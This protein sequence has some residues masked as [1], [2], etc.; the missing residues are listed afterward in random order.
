MINDSSSVEK[1]AIQSQTKPNYYGKLN[2]KFIL[3]E[4]I[5]KGAS[6]S[7]LSAQYIGEESTNNC[8]LNSHID[9]KI[10]LFAIKICK[11][12]WSTKNFIEEGRIMKYFTKNDSNIITFFE[13][14]KG[15]LIKNSKKPQKTVFY[16]VFELAENYELFDY[17]KIK[18]FG[19]KYGR[20]LFRQIISAIQTCHE[21]GIIHRDVKTENILLNGDYQCKLADFGLSVD[22]KTKNYLFGFSG[23][24]GFLPPEILSNK[25]YDLFQCDLFALGIC[26]FIIVCGFKPFCSAKRLD[27][28]YRRIWKGRYDLYWNE[29][30]NKVEFSE[31]F[32]DLINKMF[33]LNPEERLSLESIKNSYW[34][35][36]IEITKE[37]NL[38]LKKE[39]ESRKSLVEEYR[40]TKHIK[41]KK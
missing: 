29:L 27:P 13:S 9:K 7:V 35:N 5:G 33:A 25:Q 26:L 31:S 12:K 17:I 6:A 19:E 40:R 4:K 23:T 10:K 38:M 15:V 41:T 18:G 11:K 14:G 1:V 21:R 32:K 20:I 16:H 39:F 22:Q 28:L 37:D 34:L 8:C 36:E 30:P 2:N 24:D 3:L